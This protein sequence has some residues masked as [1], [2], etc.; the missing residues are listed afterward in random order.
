[1][2]SLVFKI[3]TRISA[4][5]GT[6]LCSGVDKAEVPNC[7]LKRSASALTGSTP[8]AVF[9]ILNT[10]SFVC[11]KNSRAPRARDWKCVPIIL[12]NTDQGWL[13]AAFSKISLLV[14]GIRSSWLF[15]FG[16]FVNVLVCDRAGEYSCYKDITIELN[17]RIR[18]NR[19]IVW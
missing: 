19:Q 9:F 10:Y 17:P 7:D 18:T 5:A 1:M 3:K 15:P 11:V 16:S 8:C 6:V 2:D 13:F 4:P 12:C 14:S